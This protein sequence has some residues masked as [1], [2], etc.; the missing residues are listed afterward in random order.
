MDNQENIVKDKIKNE[1]KN[2][3]KVNDNKKH[4]NRQIPNKIAILLII[5][6][7]LISLF[8]IFLAYIN[9]SKFK[10]K[11][12]AEYIFNKTNNL[13][14]LMQN[15][16]L[17]YSYGDNK[18]NV[19]SD[20]TANFDLSNDIL[21]FLGPK[22]KDIETFINNSS[23][24]TSVNID[25]LNKYMDATINYSYTDEKLP[26]NTY[27]NENQI[28]LYSKDIYDK[29]INTKQSWFN[30]DAF[31]DKLSSQISVDE[32]NYIL[33]ILK[34]SVMYSLD[35]G[36]YF[37][38]KSKIL[39]DDMFINVTKST[40]IIDTEL[41]NTF[42]NNF[43][44]S[45]IDDDR[46]MNILYKM[47]DHKKYP[48]RTSLDAYIRSRISNS[49]NQ[50]I[51]NQKIG[52]Y[53]IYTSGPFDKVER[54]EIR[55][56]N[57]NIIIQYNSHSTNN[58]DSQIAIYYGNYYLSQASIKQIALDNYNINITIGNNIEINLQGIIK[59]SFIDL[60]YLISMGGIDDIQGNIKNV[61]TTSGQNQISN[62]FVFALN[63]PDTYGTANIT[64]NNVV[65]TIDN[66]AV[67]DL[68]N[69]ED[70][71]KIT[72]KEYGQIML[73]IMA[74]SPKLLEALDNIL[75]TDLL[76]AY[77]YSM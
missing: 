57:E 43:F 72:E 50:V 31:F 14:T 53:S 10:I 28:Y 4:E 9:N 38:S 29:Y 73:N 54:N 58:Y 61:S 59:Q 55:L 30:S 42:D 33:N 22:G 70:I 76:H 37:T 47:A 46:A 3:R 19:V 63:T 66:V 24:N 34:Q 52:E 65:K 13:A 75:G 23:A 11:M 5:T 7:L 26:I 27:L 17:V 25:A 51:N 2:S 21:T 67:P 62:N 36:K 1:E 77:K 71:D 18:I 56:Y 48:D 6:T 35:Y 12:A 60:A 8:L 64:I 41:K 49:Q 68:T 32:I 74:K 16:P 39:V 40:I 20:I 15:S 44:N 69:V 45:V